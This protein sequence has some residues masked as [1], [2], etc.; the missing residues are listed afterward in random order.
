MTPLR[1][2]R[3]TQTTE[4]RIARMLYRKTS[5]EGKWFSMATN[6]EKMVI[7]NREQLRG[8]GLL[9]LVQRDYREGVS[10]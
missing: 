9:S 5:G 8:R 3:T 6:S 10:L 4:K 2:N 1:G 7:E